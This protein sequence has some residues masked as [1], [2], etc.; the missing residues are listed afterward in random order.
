MEH[1]AIDLGGRE[2]QVCVRGA[3]GRI[4]EEKRWFTQ[5]LPAYLQARPKSRVIIET[6]AEGFAVADAARACGHE[7][8]VVPSTLVKSLGVGE[9]KTK[10]DKRDA[11]KLSEVS[12]RIDLPS[13]H[14]PAQESRQLKTQLGMRD[15]LVAARTMLINNLRG[16]LRGQLG[17]SLRATPEKFVE[18]LRERVKGAL[19]SYVE[20]QLVM[21]EHANA[22]IAAADKEVAELAKAHSVCP[23]LMTVPGVG[24]VTALRFVAAVDDN[25][26]FKNAHELEAYLGLT[27]GEHSSSER[28]RRTSITKAGSTSMRWCLVQ[29][30][31]AARRARGKHPMVEW[32]REIEKRRGKRIAVIALA[33]KLAGILFA[34]WRDGTV[35]APLEGARPVAHPA[36]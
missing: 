33:R 2:S 8:R 14:V 5:E 25:T 22:Q 17:Q 28:Q 4:L 10:T 23:R 11:R 34:L 13:V 20:R 29:A 15:A 16:W 6:C 32:S 21:V 19:P 27:P 18:R 1:V 35:Y 24:P 9:R 30:A 7:V 3:D 12:C 31:W 36:P 26:R